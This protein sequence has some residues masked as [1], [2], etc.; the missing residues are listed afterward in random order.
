M[1]DAQE[2]GRRRVVRR[3]T[4]PALLAVAVALAVGRPV[5]LRTSFDDLVGDGVEAVPAS[6]RQA[7]SDL[8]PVLLWSPSDPSAAV[9]AARTLRAELPADLLAEASEDPFAALA[10]DRWGLA[11]PAD[12]RLLETPEGRARLARRALRRYVASP[13]PPLFPVAEDP[14]ALADGFV[15]AQREA[16]ANWSLRDGQLVARGADGV[17]Y[18]VLLL[19]LRPSVVADTDALI[20]F[21]GRLDAARAAVAATHPSVRTAACGVPLHTAATAGNCKRE[22][23]ALS[24]LSLVFIALL[25]VFAFR[26]VRWIPL[27]AASLTVAGLAGGVA[28]LLFFR[29]IHLMTVVLGTT[30]MGLVIDYS[31]HWLLAD[32]RRGLVRNLVISWLTTEISLLPLMLAS[33]PVL[34]QSAVFLGTGLA[35]ALAYVVWGYP[36]GKGGKVGKWESGT[37]GEWESGKVGKWEGGKAKALRL[38]FVRC[39]LSSRLRPLASVLRP[40]SSLLPPPPLPPSHPP[41]LPPS[42]PPT[43]PPSHFPAS[44]LLLLLLSAF[45]VLGLCRVR[46]GTNLTALYRPPADLAAAERLFAGL[47]GSD[48]GDRGFLVLDRRMVA[49]NVEKLFDEQGERL[50]VA[51]G[52]PELRRSVCAG[53]ETAALAAMPRPKEALPSGVRFLQPRTVLAA[54]LSRWTN[55]TL[56]RLGC[57]LALMFVALVLFDRRRAIRLFLPSALA[58]A[59]VAGALGLRGEPMNLFHLLACFLLAGMSVDYTVFLHGGGRAAWKPALCSLLTSVVGFGALAFVSFPVVQGFGFVLG[60]GLPCGFFAAW[61]TRRDGGTA[62]SPAARTAEVAATPLGLEI[63]WTLYRLLGLRA[64]HLFAASVGL[65]AWT[66]S[67]KVRRATGV[68]KLVNFTRALSDKLVVMADGRDRPRVETDGSADAAAFLDDVRAGRGVFVLSSHV[69]T[70][71]VLTALGA[72]DRTFHAWMDIDRTGVFNRFYLRHA[73]R[74]KVV[75]HPIADVGMATAFFAG[76]ALDRGDCLV[77]AGDRGRGAFRFAHAMG[78][79]VYFVAC[80]WTGRAYRA[81]IRRLPDETRA[82]ASAYDAVLHE[83]ASAYPDQWFVWDSAPSANA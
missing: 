49:A 59:V 7:S 60:V 51:L 8:V 2:E 71:E 47:G 80:V 65:C 68:R 79:S 75:I 54:V 70:V 41:T 66:C 24:V 21:R 20:A 32:A 57:A 23:N 17:D 36:R 3:W 13:L 5:A 33:L 72:C 55:E 69:G 53:A 62:A 11:A 63:L 67:R 42:P 4:V 26:S 64:L 44:K 35:A 31:F 73:N 58:I 48:E 9:A 34:R 52:L 76:E 15:R 39:P 18:V 29:E 12:V 6:V 74:A 28:L 10:A 56:V 43:L 30:V 78:H 46:F 16:R 27:L 81:V 19:R 77:M 22:I 40:L 50:R 37:V 14:F 82:M 45:A 38:S 25:S 83:L 1:T 61:A